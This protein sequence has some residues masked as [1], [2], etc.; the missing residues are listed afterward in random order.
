M[1]EDMICEMSRSQRPEK[2]KQ[3]YAMPTNKDLPLVQ[4]DRSHLMRMLLTAQ[5]EEGS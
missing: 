2:N 4:R 3:D 5:E 1:V